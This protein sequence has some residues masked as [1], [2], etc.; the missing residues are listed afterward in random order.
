[1]SEP[2]CKEWSVPANK[3]VGLCSQQYYPVSENNECP[4]CVSPAMP[5]NVCIGTSSGSKGNCSGVRFPFRASF[6]VPEFVEPFA[7]GEYTEVRSEN[8]SVSG[9]DYTTTSRII[10]KS[11]PASS[12]SNV[13]SLIVRGYNPELQDTQ[14]NACEWVDE[15]LNR[16]WFLLDPININTIITASC[17]PPPP[18]CLYDVYSC[19]VQDTI[20][21]GTSPFESEC[22]TF[23]T[24]E[25]GCHSAFPEGRPRKTCRSSDFDATW[26]LTLSGTSTIKASLRLYRSFCVYAEVETVGAFGPTSLGIRCG[27]KK[28]Y[29]FRS[30]SFL[31]KAPTD[32]G[33]TLHN[34][35][36]IPSNLGV[37]PGSK[38][39]GTFIGME[40]GLWETQNVCVPK[41]FSVWRMSKVYDVHNEYPNLTISNLPNEISVKIAAGV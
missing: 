30:N 20:R 41:T 9:T 16:R 26:V 2:V 25:S 4:I 21:T 19:S 3:F 7:N 33:Y 18:A 36:V 1:M 8:Y 39:F 6:E 15:N 37:P 17:P 29:A 5:K 31:S 28:T 22:N 23:A 38:Q 11:V 35:S 34:Y 13:T 32:L 40:V 12:M 27:S 14:D 10:W 24:D